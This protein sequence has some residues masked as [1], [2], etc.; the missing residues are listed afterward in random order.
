MNEKIY[1]I[2]VIFV[3]SFVYAYIIGTFSSTLAN[4]SQDSNAYAAKMRGVTTLMQYLGVR[5]AAGRR[6]GCAGRAG[7]SGVVGRERVSLLTVLDACR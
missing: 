7:L 4:M 2:F 5:P 3:G 1:I 6:E